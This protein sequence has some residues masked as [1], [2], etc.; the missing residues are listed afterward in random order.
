MSIYKQKLPNPVHIKPFQLAYICSLLKSDNYQITI[1][2][3]A[4]GLN[5]IIRYKSKYF[6]AEDMGHYKLVYDSN[7]YYIKHNDTLFARSEW[8]RSLHP[9]YST[10]NN[11]S[12]MASS[13]SEINKIIEFD[14][15]N[16]EK[17]I[18]NC[19]EIHDHG[20]LNSINWFPKTTILVKGFDIK[21]FLQI[22]DQK[23]SVNYLTDGW[24]VTLYYFNEGQIKL[25]FGSPL[26][27]KLTPDMTIDLFYD[28]INFSTLNGTII[29]VSNQNNKQ[30]GIWRCN[31]DHNDKIWKTA[32]SRSDKYKPNND[33]I[34]LP[35]IKYHNNPW[36]PSD[37][38]NYI[39]NDII[40][41]PNNHYNK[42][43]NSL[44][45]FLEIRKNIV[46]NYVN[47]IIKNN[48]TILDIGC[49]NGAI[50]EYIKNVKY[51]KYVGIDK[52]FSCLVHC[53]RKIKLNDDLIW[54]DI[55]LEKWNY[56]D[57]CLYDNKYDVI[58]CINVIH[59]INDDNKMKLFIDNLSK[60]SK[61]HTKF[62]LI[63]LDSNKM[64]SVDT[65]SHDD[66]II[67]AIENNKYKF[68]YPWLNREFSE[69]IPDIKKFIDNIKNNNWIEANLNDHNFDILSSDLI[70]VYKQYNSFHK[71]VL[72]VKTD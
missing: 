63:G 10:C 15:L 19:S 54:G 37:I 33:R 65:L 29:P 44:S 26:K 67:K 20:D 64:K 31:Y 8:I 42:I 66:F 70:D 49:G 2:P 45:K 38:I 53:E 5:S 1:S 4:D 21:D 14:N 55:T 51:L 60:L 30:K 7:Y 27:V 41:Y 32:S 35:I 3:K 56:F 12:Y 39:Y 40:Y 13:I 52:D 36:Y 17:F 58:V 57:D 48:S 61:K 16:F 59:Y 25:I 9:L 18:M 72:L 22:L 6:E 43:D 47:I 34:V 50:L 62:L 68:K 11:I 28:G 69:T 23:I 71:A 24:I 46:S